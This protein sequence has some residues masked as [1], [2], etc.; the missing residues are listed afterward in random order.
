M[1][2][3]RLNRGDVI[4]F[5]AA[6]ALLLILPMTWYTTQQGEQYR[7]FQHDVVPQLNQEVTPSPS[8]QA[9]Q[10]AAAQEKNAWQASGI[11]D[12][13]LLLAALGAVGLVLAAGF[14]RAAGSRPSGWPNPSALATLFG[15]VA[16]ALIAYRILVPP[17]LRVAAVVKP[18]A[19]LGLLAA[20]LMTIG[21][22]FAMLLERGASTS[23]AEGDVAQD[24]GPQPTASAD[25]VA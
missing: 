12:R 4:A 10:A 19:L 8:D 16:C 6:L 21:V 7:Q 25:P 20:A 24:S 17:G 9:A 3:K 23:A 18:G 15:L 22:R 11:V 14:M 13:L 1:T 2:F 5:V